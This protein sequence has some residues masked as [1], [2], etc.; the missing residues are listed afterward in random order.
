MGPDEYHGNVNN[1]V[2]TAV[3]ARQVLRFAIDACAAIKGC[4]A[5]PRWAAVADELY[6]LFDAAH[7]YHPEFAGYRRGVQVKQADTILLYSLPI[8]FGEAGKRVAAND[9]TYYGSNTDP[10]GPAM[11]WSAFAM[12]WLFALGNETAAAPLF[13]KGYQTVQGPY[14]VWGEVC[15]DVARI[16]RGACRC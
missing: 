6:V 10:N 15:S 9:L 5:D 7:G 1:S 3:T 12:A 11:T 14:A 8:D 16:W 13:T 2:Y 4:V